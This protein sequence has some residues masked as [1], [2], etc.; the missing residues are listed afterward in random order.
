VRLTIV[1]HARAGAK[2]TWAGPDELRPL[3]DFGV[4]QAAALAPQ[5]AAH[6]PI[7][8]LVSSPALRCV[9]TLQPLADLVA[10]PIET[11]DA[12]APHAGA[13]E[14]RATLGHPAFDDAIL[15]THGEVLR[16]L[17]RTLRRRGL[18]PNGGHLHGRQLLAKGSAWSLTIDSDGRVSSFEHLPPLRPDA[19]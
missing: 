10:V 16:P 14:L 8:R 18:A 12:L 19:S 11:W 7:G 5:L 17:L 6:G 15:C 13:S 3:D 4:A 1:R 2:R 9:Q